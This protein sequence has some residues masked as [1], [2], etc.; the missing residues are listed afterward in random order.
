MKRR[1]SRFVAAAT[2]VFLL[3]WPSIDGQTAAL[4]IT[5]K[6]QMKFGEY[7]ANPYA[8]GTVVLSSSANTTT[9]TGGLLPFGGTIKRAKFLLEGDPKAFVIVT[10]PS[11]I[12]TE[13]GT[14]G[15]TM[16]IDNFTM[17]LSNPVK[18]NNSGKKSIFIGAT[19]HV[20]TAQKKGNYNDNN[21]F[22]VFADYL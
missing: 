1:T 9:V 21:S 14:S 17:N 4:T 10:L 8:S 20:G 15:F 12:T 5:R 6:A 16:T 22:T 19:V 7:A 3:F 13:K 11:S 18:L 2:F